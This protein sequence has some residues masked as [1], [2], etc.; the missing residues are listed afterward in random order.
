[1]AIK[2]FRIQDIIVHNCNFLNFNLSESSVDLIITSPPYNIGI[3][4]GIYNDNKTYKEYLEFTKKWLGK[5]FD[6][7]K[8][9]GRICINVPIDTG[10]NGKRSLAADLTILAKRTGFKYKGTIVWDHS[11][12]LMTSSKQKKF[13]AMAFSKNIE[14]I[15]I[16]YK[17]EWISVKKEF[18]DYVN[19]IWKFSGENPKR[20]NHPA[21]FPVEIPRRLIKMFS[22][23]NDIVLDPFLGSGTTLMACKQL[24][25]KGIGIEIDE[26][27]FEGSKTRIS[28]QNKH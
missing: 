1:M 25:R 26:K 16:F 20:V 21:A 22:E 15:L 5:S 10:K 3:D 12:S 7:L 14:L 28:D 4:Y 11:T 8:S 13:Y 6:I 23:T 24:L 2:S 9:N 18:R 19:E 17:D 27:Y